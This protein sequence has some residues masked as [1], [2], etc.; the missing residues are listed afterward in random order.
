M[1]ENLKE[2]IVNQAIEMFLQYG[3]RSVSIDDICRQMGI[4]KKTFYVYFDQKS[5]LVDAILSQIT[6]QLS[7]RLKKQ[8]TEK[9]MVEVLLDFAAKERN[10]QEMHRPPQVVFDLEKYYPQLMAKHKKLIGNAVKQIVAQSLQRG[11]EE[12]VFWNNLDVEMCAEIFAKLHQYLMETVNL[13]NFKLKEHKR[14]IDC[15]VTLL[16]RGIVSDQ[17]TQQVKE[18]MERKNYHKTK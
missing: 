10:L 11:I 16:I 2:K 12:G 6:L 14:A 9:P 5:D 3:I 17:G 15:A 18:I 7:E 8:M 4:S 1:M 13:P